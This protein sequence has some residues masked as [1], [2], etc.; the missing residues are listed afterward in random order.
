MT[1]ARSRVERID[2]C[3]LFSQ[4]RPGEIINGRHCECSNFDCPSD[5]DNDLI[6][7]GTYRTVKIRIEKRT[8]EHSQRVN[9]YRA[10]HFP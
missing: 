2:F 1:N 8:S 5:P 9:N 6:C 4:L 7:G 3:V 10:K